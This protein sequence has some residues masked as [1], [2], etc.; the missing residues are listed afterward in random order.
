LLHHQTL[1]SEKRHHMVLNTSES[2]CCHCPVVCH[3]WYYP[4]P[5]QWK[6]YFTNWRF[7]T[8]VIFVIFLVYNFEISK[9]KTN[10]ITEEVSKK[11]RSYI[12]SVF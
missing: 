3:Q 2:A 5:K 11:K 1:G 8:I 7:L 4:W 12:N 9:N 10:N 6:F